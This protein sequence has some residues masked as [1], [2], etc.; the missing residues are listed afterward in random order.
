MDF[1][2]QI[3]NLLRNGVANIAFG[4]SPSG[5]PYCQATQN[6]PTGPEGCM[7]QTQHQRVA[8]TLGACLDAVTADIKHC[9]ELQKPRKSSNST[10]EVVK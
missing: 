9:S 6:I 2:T 8:A 7:L 4:T 1:E 10:L 3:K 5:D